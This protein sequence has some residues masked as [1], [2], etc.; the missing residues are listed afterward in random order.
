MGHCKRTVIWANYFKSSPQNPPITLIAITIVTNW[1]TLLNCKSLIKTEQPFVAIL[2]ILMTI[3]SSF[4]KWDFYFYG[5]LQCLWLRAN[6]Y[7]DCA[8]SGTWWKKKKLF[9]LEVACGRPRSKKR[10]GN[11]FLKNL[12]QRWL[13]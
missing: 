11:F 13:Y 12:L 3:K 5:E 9:R 8:S 10:G 4:F 6:V 2:Y 1:L 7:Y